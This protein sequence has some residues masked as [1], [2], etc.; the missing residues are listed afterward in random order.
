[1]PKRDYKRERSYHRPKGIARILQEL[2]DEDS[3]Q[4]RKDIVEDANDYEEERIDYDNH[5]SDSEQEFDRA[6]VEGD[7]HFGENFQNYI[8]KDN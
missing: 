7:L 5:Y 6:D 4:H 2:E 8:G 1:M 3:M